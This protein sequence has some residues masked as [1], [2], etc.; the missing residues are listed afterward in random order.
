MVRN[1]TF[2]EEGVVLRF[3]LLRVQAGVHIVDEGVI[4]INLMIVVCLGG[5]QR[6]GQGEVLLPDA[7]QLCQ[8]N[9][10]HQFDLVGCIWDGNFISNHCR[11]LSFDDCSDHFLR[12]LV[13]II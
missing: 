2:S 7:A 13:Q 3:L 12:R 6:R 11:L 5:R 8:S 10:T 4:Y 9:L 1:E